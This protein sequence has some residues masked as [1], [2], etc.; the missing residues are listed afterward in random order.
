MNPELPTPDSTSGWKRLWNRIAF[1]ST[2]LQA[3]LGGST[4]SSDASHLIVGVRRAHRQP[5]TSVVGPP[6]GYTLRLPPYALLLI[7]GDVGAAGDFRKLSNF[8]L[9]AL[10]KIRWRIE[11]DL[12]TGRLEAIA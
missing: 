5:T 1:C 2:K 11:H 8:P 4:P 10:G 12:R 7:D 6:A 3:L 9:G